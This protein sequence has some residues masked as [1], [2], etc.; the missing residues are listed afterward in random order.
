MVGSTLAKKFLLCFP[1]L[2]KDVLQTTM[3]VEGLEVVRKTLEKMTHGF[4]VFCDDPAMNRLVE[5]T[6][7][8]RL[9]GRTA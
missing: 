6:E 1:L 9:T 5:E 8:T 2:V 7:A 4:L 3:A